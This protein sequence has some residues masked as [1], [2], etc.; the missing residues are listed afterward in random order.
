MY[1]YSRKKK[2]FFS[3]ILKTYDEMGKIRIQKAQEVTNPNKYRS[4]TLDVD[5]LTLIELRFTLNV[6]F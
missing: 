4:D 1:I 6:D 3:F 2:V 5:N